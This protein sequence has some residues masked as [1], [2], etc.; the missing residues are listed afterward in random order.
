MDYADLCGFLWV[1]LKVLCGGWPGGSALGW[2]GAWAGVLG[3]GLI[4]VDRLVY[5]LVVVVIMW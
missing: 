5:L 4:L 1:P 3:G 2:L